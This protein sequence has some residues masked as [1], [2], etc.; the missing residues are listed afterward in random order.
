MSV[1]WVE[2]SIGYPVKS[3]KYNTNVPHWK[4][5]PLCWLP[6]Q[7]WRVHGWCVVGKKDID[8]VYRKPLCVHFLYRFPYCSVT[9][10]S[11][12]IW[13]MQPSA[14]PAP[15]RSLGASFGSTLGSLRQICSQVV[16]TRL[17]FRL[18]VLSL[19]LRTDPAPWNWCRWTWSWRVLWLDRWI[20]DWGL[21]LGWDHSNEGWGMP[22]E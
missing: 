18:V 20:A 1:K 22:T 6:S 10:T 11:P 21:R 3:Y 12:D 14:P 9:E 2:G 19:P 16:D 13:N 4:Q 8:T 5:R 17:L 15:T 7:V